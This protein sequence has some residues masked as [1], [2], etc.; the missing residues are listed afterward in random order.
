MLKDLRLTVWRTQEIHIGAKNP[1]NVNFAIIKNQVK[2]IDTVKYFQQSLASLAKSMTDDEQE[3]VKRTCRNFIA[4]KLMLLT[5]E[6]E[7]WVLDYLCSGKGTIP[8]QIVKTLDSLETKPENGHF[9]AH[10]DFYSTL[11][12]NN[13]SAEDYENVKKNFKLLRLK[14]FGDLNKI[15]NFQDVAI[16][17]EIFEKRA[18]LL[19]TL[20]KYNP[21]KCNSA[22]GFSG[23]VQRLQS[24]SVIALPVD[25]EIIRVFEKTLI[26]GYSCVN[27]RMAFDTEVFLK[28]VE[29]EKVLFKS[30]DNQL[31]RF[32]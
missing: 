2:F 26:G 13:I 14:T 19:Q 27:T 30:K 21:R 32:S 25:A 6:N 4:N 28:D 22:S 18:S 3:N 10:K 11:S 29:N 24:K 16:L 23:C 8:Y 5:E 9:F 15:C 7:K 20:F 1:S 12:E 17:S 31:K